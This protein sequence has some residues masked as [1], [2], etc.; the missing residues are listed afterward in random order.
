MTKH[1]DFSKEI[2]D[3]KE[4]HRGLQREEEMNSFLIHFIEQSPTPH[5]EGL[6]RVVRTSDIVERILGVAPVDIRSASESSCIFTADEATWARDYIFLKSTFHG[7][8]IE[9]LILDFLTYQISDM[10]FHKSPASALITFVMHNI[11]KYF[12]RHFG[13][14]NLAKKSFMDRRFLAA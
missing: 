9:L 12:R 8:E 7:I 6:K 10:I 3:F 11:L 14:R 4:Q 2:L 13:S 5:Q 1:Y